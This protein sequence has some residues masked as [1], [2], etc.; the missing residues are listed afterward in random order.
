MNKVFRKSL[1]LGAIRELYK[2]KKKKG[3]MSGKL[4]SLFCWGFRKFL[5]TE[6]TNLLGKPAVRNFDLITSTSSVIT[7]TSISCNAFT[8]FYPA[9]VYPA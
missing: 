9:P 6:S 5:I 4:S 8:P 1:I 7:S 2:Y 3:G